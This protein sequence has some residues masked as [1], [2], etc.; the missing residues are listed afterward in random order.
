MNRSNAS[1]TSVG[2]VLVIGPDSYERDMAGSRPYRYLLGVAIDCAA[3]VELVVAEA[4]LVGARAALQV[5]EP[6]PIGEIV[7]AERLTDAGAE[8]DLD[9]LVDVV[10]G[11]AGGRR[12]DGEGVGGHR[13][14]SDAAEGV[15]EAGVREVIEPA[16]ELG[17]VGAQ[18]GDLVERVLQRVGRGGQGAGSRGAVAVDR[19][20]P[21]RGERVLQAGELD[22]VVC[23]SG[24]L[25]DPVW[26]PYGGDGGSGGA[27]KPLWG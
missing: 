6:D 13:D 27:P 1:R 24:L 16:G 9:D 7:R 4:A 19:P 15:G 3:L 12:P 2:R 11:D 14:P 20:D 25:D 10:A 5:L 17:A 21:D 26:G 23:G 22:Q 8:R 18:H